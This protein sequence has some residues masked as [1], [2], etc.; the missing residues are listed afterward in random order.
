MGVEGGWAEA[1]GI[2]GAG[3]ELDVIGA[4]V[5]PDGAREAESCEMDW[6]E[7]LRESREASSASARD[8]ILRIVSL[9]SMS[10]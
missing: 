3:R 9:A 7:A 5:L 10:S 8:F 2:E 4:G 1:G 6:K